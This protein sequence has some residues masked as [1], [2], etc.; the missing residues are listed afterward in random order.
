MEMLARFSGNLVGRPQI[1][2]AD[3]RN[4]YENVNGPICAD[5]TRSYLYSNKWINWFSLLRTLL[6]VEPSSARF[7]GDGAELKS[8]RFRFAGAAPNSARL[9]DDGAELK[10]A[11]CSFAGAAP[12]SARFADDGAEPRSAWLDGDGVECGGYGVTAPAS[13]VFVMVNDIELNRVTGD[14]GASRL[15]RMYGINGVKISAT[16]L[17]ITV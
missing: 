9:A 15:F 13:S 17:L 3:S 14:G 11:R 5:V 2:S 10:S 4:A 7:G 16:C 8:A 6:G 1:K 12:N